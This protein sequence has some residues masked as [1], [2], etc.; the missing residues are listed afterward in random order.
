M[1]PVR[2]SADNRFTDFLPT[3]VRL[4]QTCLLKIREACLG[5]LITPQTTSPT[6]ENNLTE[7]T[8]KWAAPSYFM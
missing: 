8:D 4:S 2:K 3:A 7:V 6:R 5:A 1:A